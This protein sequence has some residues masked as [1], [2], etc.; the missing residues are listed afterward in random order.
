LQIGMTVENDNESVRMMSSGCT[1]F[2]WDRLDI[3]LHH[4]LCQQHHGFFWTRLF[5]VIAEIAACSRVHCNSFHF[6]KDNYMY[7]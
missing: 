7:M 1:T 4:T 2:S 3:D 5:I 6:V